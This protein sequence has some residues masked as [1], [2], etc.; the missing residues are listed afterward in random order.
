M[1]I[2]G[3]EDVLGSNTPGSDGNSASVNKRKHDGAR[4]LEEPIAKKR[5]K[6]TPKHGFRKPKSTITITTNIIPRNVDVAYRD[7]NTMNDATNDVGTKEPTTKKKRKAMPLRGL[8]KMKSSTT[9]STDQILEPVEATSLNKGVMDDG[10]MADPCLAEISGPQQNDQGAGAIVTGK[11]VASMGR[12]KGGIGGSSIKSKKNPSQ[13]KQHHNA[14]IHQVAM[15][16]ES[17]K[18]PAPTAEQVATAVAPARKRK[19]RKSIGQQ[20]TKRAKKVVPNARQRTTGSRANHETSDLVNE[21][22]EDTIELAPEMLDTGKLQALDSVDRDCT[23]QLKN[24]MQHPAPSAPTETS[25]QGP[26]TVK[27]LNTTLDPPNKETEQQLKPKPRRKRRSI[28]QARKSKPKPGMK[29]DVQEGPP[30]EIDVAPNFNAASSATSVSSSRIR[31]RKPLS[32]ITNLTP[33]LAKAETTTAP[34]KE[35]TQPPAPPKKRGRP[36]KNLVTN[37]GD[38][39]ASGNNLKQP[40]PMSEPI[41]PSSTKP[42]AASTTTAKP[43]AK[44][45]KILKALQDPI[46]R[47]VKL[48]VRSRLDDLDSDSDDPLSG[49]SFVRLKKTFKPVKVAAR[50]SPELREKHIA[51]PGT[52]AEIAESEAKLTKMMNGD[53]ILHKPA[54]PTQRAKQISTPQGK[55][56]EDE[57]RRETE[58]KEIEGLLSSIGK[59]V[60]RGRAMAASE[61]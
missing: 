9:A 2:D 18:E 24:D 44:P 56:I 49:A 61:A 28:T 37:K 21:L 20:S 15:D 57:K 10:R 23:G 43:P 25:C 6:A 46:R 30:E 1:E 54:K 27:D 39:S 19:K 13:R 11:E 17:R 22:L 31:R 29:N 47:V 60:K 8:Q 7:T 4:D 5:R 58:Q 41:E 38:T 45:R 16:Q 14:D 42:A 53:S 40:A 55:S 36:P 51:R 34:A 26:R 3:E 50:C 52:S 33:D 35:K 32:N 12:A 48:P 59:A